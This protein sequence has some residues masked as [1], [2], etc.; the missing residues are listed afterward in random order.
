MRSTGTC[1]NV[2]PPE[3]HKSNRGKACK[4]VFDT[5]HD[6]DVLH[7]SEKQAGPKLTSKRAG[8]KGKIAE[9]DRA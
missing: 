3:E 5:K 8:T 7:R 9:T 2:S 6:F 4:F 1:S